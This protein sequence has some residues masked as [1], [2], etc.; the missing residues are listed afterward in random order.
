MKINFKDTEE[1]QLFVT[2]CPHL[3]HQCQSWD[4]PLWKMRGYNSEKEMT[5]GIISKINETCRESDKL[6]V[7]GDFCLNTDFDKFQ[8]YIW[9]IKPQV[10]MIFGNHNHP[11]DKEFKKMCQAEYG[12][13]GCFPFENWLGKVNVLGHYVELNWNKKFV[14]CNHYAYQVWNKSHHGSWSIVS[15]SHG[16]LPA[17]LP[18]SKVGKQLDCGWDVHGKPLSFEDIKKIMDK[19]NIELV[20]HHN[21]KT[22]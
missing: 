5:D 12:F 2:G 18:E 19:K 21:E 16:S 22:T 14:T 11:W 10:C 1:S 17:I 8:E 9:R 3:G 4:N 13:E 6:L 15:H 20:D 7:L